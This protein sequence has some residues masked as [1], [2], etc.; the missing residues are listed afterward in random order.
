[1]TKP[2]TS[3]RIT[4]H[5]EGDRCYASVC[6]LPHYDYVLED[7]DSRHQGYRDGYRAARGYYGE[8]AARHLL[9]I[10]S[11]TEKFRSRFDRLPPV[12]EDL[13]SQIDRHTEEH[14]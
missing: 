6:P 3:E 4:L 14:R 1:M 11:V 8:N 5:Y 7:A 12:V 9:E 10:R 13:L 2:P